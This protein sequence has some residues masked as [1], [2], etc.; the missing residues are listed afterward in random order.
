M[1]DKNNP[2]A[3]VGMLD[4]N[5]VSFQLPN[6]YQF[7]SHLFCDAIVKLSIPGPPRGSADEGNPF[8]IY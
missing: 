4:T 7:H 8:T 3:K 2:R 5:L 1:L 6:P